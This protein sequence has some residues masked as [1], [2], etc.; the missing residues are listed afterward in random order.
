[1]KHNL[2][3]ITDVIQNRRTIFPE[4]FSGRKVH[5]EMIEKVLSNAIWAPTHGNT[6][7]WRFS[8]FMG[9]GLGKLSHFLGESYRD[10]TDE[11]SFIAGKFD[12]IISR[13]LQSSAVIGIGVAFDKNGRISKQD[14]IAAVSCAVQNMYL[15]C[16]AYGLGAFWSTPNFMDTAGINAFLELKEDDK[17]LGFF[18][19]GYPDIPWPKGQRKPTE[20]VTTWITQ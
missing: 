3:E 19:I 2:S 17:C 18:Y 5:V 6:Q 14:E 7:P 13:P 8:V 20:Y 11:K 1:M 10:M 9:N 4:Q 12:K 15:T 16:T